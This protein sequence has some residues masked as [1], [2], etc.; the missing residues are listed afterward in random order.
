VYPQGCYLNHSLAPLRDENGEVQGVFAVSTKSADQAMDEI[1]YRT[2]LNAAAAG[3]SETDV[4]GIFTYVNDRYC[5]MV[6][7]SRDELVGRMTFT[8]VTHPEDVP[9]NVAM[10]KT[11]L[12]TGQPFSIEKRFLRPDNSVIW[13]S[14]YVSCVGLPSDRPGR[15]I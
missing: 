1:S 9:D 5:D 8:E 4:N 14:T 2:L 6:G 7:R 12:D 13:A 10:V 11:M 15:Q 3:I